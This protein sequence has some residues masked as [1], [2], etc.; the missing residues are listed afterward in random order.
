MHFMLK[1]VKMELQ[2]FALLKLC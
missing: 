2:Y 1:G